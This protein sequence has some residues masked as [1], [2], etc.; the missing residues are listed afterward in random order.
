[1]IFAEAEEK[2]PDASTSLRFSTDDFPEAARAKVVR[3]LHE[4]ATL[5]NKGRPEPLE[6]LRDYRVR[7]NITKRALPGAIIMS[8]ML[9]GVRHAIRS[10]GSVSSSEDDLL[11]AV[12][13]SGRTTAQ[14]R[15]REFVLRDGDAMLMTRD[16][17]S[18]NFIHPMP[19]NFLGFRV[20]REAIAPLAGSIDDALVRMLP[21]GSDAIKLLVTY[22]RAIAEEQQSPDAP[23]L[24][25][26]VVTHIYDLIALAAGATPD[27]QAIA[28]GRGIRAARLRV[29]MS[30]I[31]ANLGDCD[32]TVA[33]V[34]QRQR[35]T[36]RY[37]HK[38]FEG[39]ELTFSTFILCQRLS[40]AH[41]M[42]CDPRFDDRSISSVAFDV[43]FSDLSYFNRTFRRRYDATPS[44]IR[45]SAVRNDSSLGAS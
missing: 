35:V 34:A 16:S 22:A 21:A 5:T 13:L 10:R 30:D 38:L 43:G 40:R 7:L 1:M 33:A 24:Q 11:V 9:C 14:L 18:L 32:L 4:R 25:R 17:V 31:T 2:M 28:K 23:E 36:P 20:P 39:E 19:V 3:E 41:R 37:L 6:P 8:G 12:N 42:L 26:L 44:D 29:I 15:D 45:H 27:G